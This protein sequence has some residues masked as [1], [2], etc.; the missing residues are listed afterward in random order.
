MPEVKKA[1]ILAAGIGTRF[2]PL[3][4]IVPKEVFPL[5]DKPAIQYIFEEAK[6]SG[7]PQIIFVLNPERRDVLDYFTRSSK[8][9]R[10]LKHRKKEKLLAE[11]AVLQEL[12]KGVSLSCVF[13]KKPLGDGQAILEAEIKVGKE[14]F[15]VL[16]CDDIFEAKPPALSQL[17]DVFRTCQRPIVALARVSKEDVSRY[18]VCEVEKIANRFFKIKRVVEKPEKDKAPSN[19]VVVGKYILVPEIFDYLRKTTP[20]ETG[21]IILA[22]AIE[23]ILK[24]GKVVYGYELRGKWLDC[25][26]KLGWLKSNLYFSLNHPQFGEEL[27]KYLKEII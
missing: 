5:V 17:L 18:G 9:E 6:T 7:I 16:F 14:P 19:L 1:V 2:L 25:G 20:L 12:Q 21:E 13:Q 15:A 8:L 26:S 4:K 11:L 3:S 27:K 10:L 23:N 24:D 22:N